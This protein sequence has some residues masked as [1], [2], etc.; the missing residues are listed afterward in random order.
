MQE[1]I[2]MKKTLNILI[3]EDD[4][5]SSTMLA[6]ILS[7]FGKCDI[8][9]DG[10]MAVAAFETGHKNKTPYDLVCLDIMLPGLDGQ[11]ALQRIRNWERRYNINGLDGVKIIMATSLE[12]RNNVMQAFNHQCEGYIVKPVTKNLVLEQLK[13]L[14]LYDNRQ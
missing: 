7:P 5:V 2:V 4:V 12:D 10:L 9:G 8:V 11:E 3:V 14:G 13:A 1:M 6:S